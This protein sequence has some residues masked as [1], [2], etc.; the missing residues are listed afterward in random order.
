[1]CR[2]ELAIVVPVCQCVCPCLGQKEIFDPR[3]FLFIVAAAAAS[4]AHLHRMQVSAAMHTSVYHQRTPLR[5]RCVKIFLPSKHAHTSIQADKC[6]IIIIIYCHLRSH[7]PAANFEWKS[8]SVL[9]AASPMHTSITL[10]RTAR[11]Q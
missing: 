5:W 2:T 3:M 8:E 4:V 9:R 7:C 1:M 10:W 11:T 6:F